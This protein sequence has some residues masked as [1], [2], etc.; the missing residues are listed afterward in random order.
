M[1]K[2][3]Q[4]LS[5]NLQEGR[6]RL[7]RPCRSC[8]RFA[9][10][11]HHRIADHRNP[12]WHK[13]ERRYPHQWTSSTT[14]LTKP[15]AE[16]RGGQVASYSKTASQWWTNWWL[17]SGSSVRRRFVNGWGWIFSVYAYPG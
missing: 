9:A 7:P 2:N 11:R 3:R 4:Y 8:S 10:L 13:M 15:L 6:H 1:I 14:A 17:E 16:T 12:Q 5:L